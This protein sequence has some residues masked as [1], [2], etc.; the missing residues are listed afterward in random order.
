MREPLGPR[1]LILQRKKA[2][3]E[4]G[5]SPPHRGR[6]AS[7][8]LLF[9]LTSTLLVLTPTRAYA[10]GASFPASW[11][12]GLRSP[13]EQ[14]RVRTLERLLRD[15]EKGGRFARAQ[16]SH[17]DRRIRRSCHIVLGRL[18]KPEDLP[19]LARGAED[20]DRGVR[21]AAAGAYITTLLRENQSV[22]LAVVPAGPFSEKDAHRWVGKEIRATIR[23][24]FHRLDPV[25]WTH[26]R[27]YRPIVQ[28]GNLAESP[29]IEIIQD[30]MRTAKYRGHAMLALSRLRRKDSIPLFLQILQD[31]IPIEVLEAEEENETDYA[32]GT[33]ISAAA[34]SLANI[35]IF[36]PEVFSVLVQ[37]TDDLSD[38]VR[39]YSNWALI[40]LH[41]APREGEPRA[42]LSRCVSTQILD[43]R[44]DHVLS[45]VSYVAQMHNLTETVPDLL[46]FL[47]LDQGYVRYE[48]ME[49]LLFLAGEEEIVLK[50]AKTAQKIDDF[51]ALSVLVGKHL[52]QEFD[53]KVWTPRLIEQVEDGTI[54]GIL[55]EDGYGRKTAM[56]ALA[57]LGGDDA[58]LALEGFLGDANDQLR[59]IAA[60]QLAVMLNKKSIAPLKKVLDDRN[61]YVRLN[62]ARTLLL[63]GDDAGLPVLVDLLGGG[64]VFVQ[65]TAA[66]IL[67][68]S[69]QENLGFD[70]EAS[71]S[72]REEG[73]KRW[74]AWVRAH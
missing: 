2:G 73:V 23:G 27:P 5:C 36:T 18:A 12:K 25:R 34:A 42:L 26:D 16:I 70:P 14:T 58:R 57:L 37:S 46:A 9:I 53:P 56:K 67:R 33:L 38:K 65:R 7:S 24:F 61:E 44:H 15:P 29:L 43:E 52:E 6:T 1:T 22:D 50:A 32:R 30:R 60:S 48:I 69:T 35:G 17:P 28:F 19:I 54:S 41:P 4:A 68:Y 21:E 8:F 51:P 31:D 66:Q 47:D 74:Q 55:D 63:L 59:T 62:A 72:K 45:M 10:Q 64:N 71:P 13:L 3:G 39:S 20:S 49:A 40:T 11:E